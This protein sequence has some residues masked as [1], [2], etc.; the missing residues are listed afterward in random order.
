MTRKRA[1]WLA[2]M[3]GLFMVSSGVI[4]AQK[5]GDQL[6]RARTMVRTD[7]D[8]AWLG[9]RLNDVTSEKAKEAK[10]PGEYGA[11]V[12]RVQQDSPAAK[13]GIEKEDVILEFAGAR[14]WSAAELRRMLEETPAGRTVELR[15][16]RAGQTRNLSVKLEGRGGD[17]LAL[18]GPPAMLQVPHVEV[19][20]FEFHF[21]GMDG[22]M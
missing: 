1:L 19:Q 17:M 11:V 12:A 22:L 21:G 13:A 18:A 8:H 9:V 5:G 3:L 20:P 15:V 4:L 14:V 16:S 10:L 6:L 2:A 7:G